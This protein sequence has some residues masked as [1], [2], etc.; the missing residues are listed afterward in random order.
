MIGVTKGNFRKYF[1]Y[2]LSRSK[3][4]I[5][6]FSLLNFLA[7]VF[8]P[9]VMSYGFKDLLYEIS[10]ADR[11]LIYGDPTFGTTVFPMIIIPIVVIM[12]TVSTV[13]SL[14]LYH[15]RADMDT[16]GCLPVS[17]GERF[18]GDFLS[19]IFANFVSYIPFCVISLF[20][21][22]STKATVEDI[23]NS[24]F[25]IDCRGIPTFFQNLVI[26]TF[27]VYLGVYA[28]TTF[29]SS[30]CGKTGNSVLFSFIAMAVLPGIFIVYGNEM[31]FYALGI[32]EFSEIAKNVCMLP[33]LGP[34]IS[35]IMSNFDK[36]YSIWSLENSGYGMLANSPFYL[37]VFLL[38]TAAF[39]AGAY[40]IGKHRRAEK[41][42]EGFVFTGAYHALIITFLVTLIGASAAGYS[43][44]MEGN[45]GMLFVALFS[46]IVYAALEFSQNKSFKKFWKTAVRFAAV[47]G[48]CFAFLTL[49]KTTNAFGIYKNLPSESSVKTVRLS[50]K[51]FY[52][53]HYINENSYSFSSDELISEVLNEHEM[54]LGSAD[55]IK[56]GDDLQ[57]TYVLNTG[58][59]ISRYYTTVGDAPDD[60]VKSF[61]DA[62]KQHPDFDLGDLGLISSKD[63]SPYL[64]RYSEHS[65]T[66][67]SKI[68]RPD[69]V[70]ELAEIL[71]DDIK[72]NYD[73]SEGRVGS[74]AFLIKNAERDFAGYYDINKSY[75]RTLAFLADPDNF[76]DDIEGGFY[77]V[78]LNTP[79]LQI[80]VSF[81][82]DDTSAAAK[83]LMS[84]FRPY[85]NGEGYSNSLYIN[86]SYTYTKYSI[87]AAD[88][89]AATKAL[90]TL[91]RERNLQ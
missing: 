85:N 50:G 20:V 75:E 30:C 54:L 24:K 12:I 11:A 27:F 46:F 84:Y 2:K 56:T 67:S 59:T 13:K 81:M 40:F 55:S 43:K 86:D 21:T 82:S 89:E 52:S 39:I 74:I 66:S 23:F 88:E 31:F 63:F 49:V 47:F 26:T 90:I 48:V 16:L 76:I 25:A 32:D 77:R 70:A 58:Q 51:Y 6:F 34:F 35:L 22:E 41:V 17:Y 69:K 28:I 14:K 65:S 4:L 5:F 36:H 3:K 33:P 1:C 71:L 38:I 62:V 37:V 83:E 79:E 29:V 8:P 7:L 73:A 72:K 9:I 18:W 80:T 57:I 45:S 42:G 44:M 60:P 15:N 61:S 64:I 19:G 68:V 10:I 91:F 87:E 53:D 78:H